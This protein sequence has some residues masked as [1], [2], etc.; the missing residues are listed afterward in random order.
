MVLTWIS[1]L[2]GHDEALDDAAPKEEGVDAA[3]DRG[4]GKKTKEAHDHPQAAGGP[5]TLSEPV[6]VA[7]LWQ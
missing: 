3:A 2:R 1:P 4:R 7:G 6:G 5:C